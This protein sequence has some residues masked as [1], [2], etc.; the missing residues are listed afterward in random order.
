MQHE[1][2]L[3]GGA[4]RGR[5]GALQLE[6]AYRSRIRWIRLD[7]QLELANTMRRMEQKHT[8]D[9]IMCLMD[10]PSAYEYAERPWYRHKQSFNSE[11][12]R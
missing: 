5:E 6:S 4:D 10:R 8:A 7:Y 3:V 1:V 11:G 2:H 9:W 12:G